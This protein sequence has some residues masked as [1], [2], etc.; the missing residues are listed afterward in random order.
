METIFDLP[1]H[2]LM[3]HFPAV[4]IPVLAISS[5]ALV[6]LPRERERYGVVVMALAVLTVVS[7]FLAAN[8]GQSLADGLNYPESQIGVHRQFG[9]TLR[10]F[11]LI[12]GV[13]TIAL[14]T[15]AGTKRSADFAARGAMLVRSAV[16]I[17]ALLSVVWAV[18]TGHEGA[19]SAWQETGALLTEEPAQEIAS[20]ATTSPPAATTGVSSTTS[21]ATTSA[22]TTSPPT[23][24]TGVSSTTSAATTSL[25]ATTGVSST[26]SAATTSAVTTSDTT[27]APVPSLDPA[28][29]YSQTCS[30]CHGDQGQGVPPRPSLIGVRFEVD[31]VAE[32][33]HIVTNGEG[34]M[35][36]FGNELTPDQIAAVSQYVLD[37]F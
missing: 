27:A 4:A 7:T 1:A 6:F 14:L 12:L 19:K 34:F 32:V 18:R 10:W 3:V 28:A 17:S 37:T 30:R 29:I 15:R 35:P 21:A 2:P 9:E 20:A 16:L 24:T 8:S 22:A 5:S 26:T 11:V 23:A 13:S 36:A 31:G 25:P 33:I